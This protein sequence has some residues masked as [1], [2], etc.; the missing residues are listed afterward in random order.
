MFPLYTALIPNFPAVRT[1]LPL[2]FTPGRSEVGSLC[3]HVFV[4]R[5]VRNV[6]EI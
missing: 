2:T 1:G 6:V 4:R 5:V 3:V